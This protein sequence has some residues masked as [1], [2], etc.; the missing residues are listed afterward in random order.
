MAAGRRQAGRGKESQQVSEPLL[1]SFGRQRVEDAILLGTGNKVR[2]GTAKG[3]VTYIRDYVCFCHEMEWENPFLEGEAEVQAIS[4]VHF[5]LEHQERFRGTGQVGKSSSALRK[6]LEENGVPKDT[7]KGWF[8]GSRV[9]RVRQEIRAR[10]P[11]LEL[12]RK[13]EDN[14]RELVTPEYL[15]MARTVYGVVYAP[16][17]PACPFD[18]NGRREFMKCVCLHL[19][20][21]WHTDLE[22]R[23]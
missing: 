2:S 15:D 23:T 1:R 13:K 11:T 4:V 16:S 3:Y 12:L 22:A 17:D 21:L 19:T 18:D 10:A 7:V 8:E 6:W 9:K 20:L 14:R 5:F